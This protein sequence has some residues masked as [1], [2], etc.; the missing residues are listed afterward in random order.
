[1]TNFLLKLTEEIKNGEEITIHKSG[2]GQVRENCVY[3]KSIE[4][5][6]K[7]LIED[8]AAKLN[9]NETITLF[10]I[11]GPATRQ[12]PVYICWEEVS[13]E[14]ADKVPGKYGCWPKDNG[15]NTLKVVDGKCYNLPVGLRSS[16]LTEEIPEWVSEA[17]KAKSQSFCV[18]I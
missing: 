15:D 6:P 13:A 4:Q 16:L 7:H 3:A 10:A 2:V 5:V 14:N 8:G 11:E 18:Q 9:E 1:M 12:F 17:L